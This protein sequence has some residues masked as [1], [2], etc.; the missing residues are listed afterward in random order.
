MDF[1]F[2]LQ[3]TAVMCWVVSYGLPLT[4][5]QQRLPRCATHSVD[6]ENPLNANEEN[7]QI[8][9]DTL[10]CVSSPV[11][12]PDEELDSGKTSVCPRVHLGSRIQSRGKQKRQAC[13]TKTTPF[14]LGLTSKPTGYSR[15]ERTAMAGIRGS[16]PGR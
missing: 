12:G 2:L 13:M 14:A 6:V 15:H 8:E 11:P 10:D 5:P 9:S 16:T 1:F 3:I 7:T 4:T